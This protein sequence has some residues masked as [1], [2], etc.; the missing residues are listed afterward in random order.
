MSRSR[1]ITVTYPCPRC[2][3]AFTVTAYPRIPASYDSPAEGGD[4]DPTECFNCC[5]PVDR[6]EVCQLAADKLD[7]LLSEK[8]ER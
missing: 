1:T 4:I 3:R 8:Y 6:Y 2:R 7:G 5:E